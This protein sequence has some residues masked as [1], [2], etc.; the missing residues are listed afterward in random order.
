M[1]LVAAVMMISATTP[2]FA[3]ESMKHDMQRDVHVKMGMAVHEDAKVQS[4]G[5]K[6][7]TPDMKHDMQRDVHVALGMAA[8]EG[9]N[10][11]VTQFTSSINESDQRQ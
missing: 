5:T 2:V 6:T 4:T 10:E 9:V 8:K 11:S 1:A 7:T 3:A